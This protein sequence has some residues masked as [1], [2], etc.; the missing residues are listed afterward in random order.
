MTDSARE[1]LGTSEAIVHLRALTPK[2]ARSDAPVLISGS[3]GTG[4]EQFARILH[5]LSPR[6]NHP[7]VAINCAAIPDSLFESELFG[8]ERGSFT[9]AHHA[10]R[11]K[12][13]LADGGVL[14]LDEV[15]ELSPLCQSKLLRVL[16]EHEVQPI[17]ASHPIKVDFRLIAATNRSVEAQVERG[18]FRSDLYYRLNVARIAIPDLCERPQDI[19][20]YLD[21][22][23]Q[24][25]NRRQGTNVTAPSAE[26]MEVLL[27]YR[28]PGNVREVRNFVEAVF[29]DPPPGTIG[30]RDIPAAFAKLPASY[31]R[32]GE[33][34][35]TRLI[36]ALHKTDWNKAEAAKALQWSR[37]TLYRKITKYQV[38]RSGHPD[39]TP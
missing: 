32:P 17:G 15:G 35:R 33:D 22:F 29:I 11:G 26:L 23:I 2:I 39:M 34:E 36:A 24:A 1:L 25:F 3:T 19:S 4:K 6:A 21:H 18:E 9:G 38:T 31:A 28:W 20:V 7:F 16:E 5:Q 10:Q 37:M 14:F 13:A 27:N 12:A 30:L 8:F